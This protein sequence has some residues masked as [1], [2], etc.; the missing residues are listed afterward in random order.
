MAI[1]I[2]GAGLV[3][4]Q[5]ARIEYERGEKPIL[6]ARHPKKKAIEEIVVSSTLRVVQGDILSMGKFLRLIK[7]EGIDK[8]IHTAANP[9]LTAGAQEKPLAAIK[10]NIMGTANV[11]EAARITGVKRVVFTSSSVL[12]GFMKPGEPGADFYT[13]A[14]LPKPTSIYA[15]TKLA[16]ENLGLVYADT[17]GLDFVA[18]RLAAVFGPWIGP[19]GGGPSMAVRDIIERSFRGEVCKIYLG[20]REYVYSKDAAQGAVLACHKE[21]L[22]HRV[23]NIGM[24]EKVS[25]EEFV[26]ALKNII[27]NAKLEVERTTKTAPGFANEQK[28]TPMSAKLSKEE[29]GYKPKYNME[30]AIQDYV[31]WLSNRKR[32]C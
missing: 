24:G 11:L 20:T 31:E 14:F 30:K 5:I 17:Y 2:T 16:C 1:L 9:M 6:L 13:E 23:F 32:L 4:S 21:G 12:Y 8:I 18:V 3:G 27:P 29:L 22:R 7:D 10:V 25:T 28:P 19:G 26:Q 15:A